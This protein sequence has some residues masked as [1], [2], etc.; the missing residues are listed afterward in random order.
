MRNFKVLSHG[1]ILKCAIELE[2][3]KSLQKS[4]GARIVLRN[5]TF[6]NVKNKMAHIVYIKKKTEHGKFLSEILAN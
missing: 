2:H 5:M 4:K 1:G 3:P 6:A